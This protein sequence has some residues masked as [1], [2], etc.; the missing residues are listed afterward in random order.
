MR[1]LIEYF[2]WY[3]NQNNDY[4]TLIEKIHNITEK[5]TKVENTGCQEW[6]YGEEKSI[7]RNT[8][9]GNLRNTMSECA[10]DARCAGVQH[11]CCDRNCKL[12]KHGQSTGTARGLQGFSSDTFYL[13]LCPVQYISWQNST[14]S[15]VNTCTYQKQIS[16]GKDYIIS[17][18]KLLFPF[19]IFF[20]GIS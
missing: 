8:Y 18:T 14:I 19:L 6:A 13:Q 3:I 7:L 15:D 11:N 9:H 5:F 10:Y 20:N 16:P 4:N 12:Q 1:M 17:L 2:V